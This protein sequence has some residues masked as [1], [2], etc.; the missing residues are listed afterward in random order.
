MRPGRRRRSCSASVV[1]RGPTDGAARSARRPSRLPILAVLPW[2]L[3]SGHEAW[4]HLRAHSF[5]AEPVG[6]DAGA[7]TLL[8]QAGQLAAAFFRTLVHGIFYGGR[9]LSFL[10]SPPLDPCTGT[11]A[12]VGIFLA[13]FA[14]GWDR[15]ARLLLAAWFFCAFA[16]GSTSQYG[17][18]PLTRLFFLAPFHAVF[19]AQAALLFS[20]RLGAILPR[21]GRLVPGLVAVTAT[22]ACVAGGIR[23][24]RQNLAARPH[25][26]GDGTTTE[27]IRLAQA[28]PAGRGQVLFLQR[29]TTFMDHADL[30]LEAYGF[31][32][33][34]R[35]YGGRQSWP[36]PADLSFGLREL[37]RIEP[38]FLAVHDA[39]EPAVMAEARS[40]LRE[41][42][43]RS[44]WTDSAPGREWS[45]SFFCVA[46]GTAPRDPRETDPPAMPERA[47]D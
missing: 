9:R 10:S 34:I 17:Y 36:R 40:I 28:C 32:G 23:A 27:L 6:R 42:F 30:W 47:D 11:L 44:H 7:P 18:P 46:R 15:R 1:A 22:A 4:D 3:L 20:E 43:P 14:A 25:G 13:A 24:L 31:D 21:R 39:L 38:P 2:L 29:N 8:A 37:R 41:R 19:A 16:V 45:L 12:F 33:R 26:F 35:Y 5:L